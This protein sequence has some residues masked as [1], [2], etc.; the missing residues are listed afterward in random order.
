MIQKVLKT[1][2]RKQTSLPRDPR[3]GYTAVKAVKMGHS[4][5]NLF[6][7]KILPAIRDELFAL[8]KISSSQTRL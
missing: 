1:F 4:K 6:R 3:L 2:S 7:K 8:S 5:E